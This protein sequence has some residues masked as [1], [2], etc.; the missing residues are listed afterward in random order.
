MLAR[1]RDRAD[2]MLGRGAVGLSIDKEDASQARWSKSRVHSDVQ[3]SN[4]SRSA[5]DAVGRRAERHPNL[6]RRLACLPCKVSVYL[7]NEEHGS[8]IVTRFFQMSVPSGCDLGIANHVVVA[9]STIALA[10]GRGD[11]ARLFRR[12][13]RLRQSGTC[14]SVR[15]T[16]IVRINTKLLEHLVGH[17]NAIRKRGVP[18]IMTETLYRRPNTGQQVSAWTD[19]PPV[20]NGPEACRNAAKV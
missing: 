18:H 7:A 17:L 6:P 16:A 15:C 9:Q 14:A 19:D 2:R 3:F 8:Y 1:E 11:C 10:G 5:S 4:K 20:A 13:F 12:E